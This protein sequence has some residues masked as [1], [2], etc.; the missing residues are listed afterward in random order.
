MI[1]VED[2]ESEDQDDEDEED[3]DDNL[4]ARKELDDWLAKQDEKVQKLIA[5]GTDGLRSALKKERDAAKKAAGL[6]KDLKDANKKLDA[7]K[8]DEEKDLEASEAA[9][10]KLVTDSAEA[11]KTAEDAVANLQK[12]RIKNAITI[13][14]L[15]EGFEDP[16]DAHALLAEDAV[17]IDE[18][19]DKVVGVKKALEKLLK[20]KPYLAGS[21][22]VGT[23]RGSRR[24]KLSSD[25]KAEPVDEVRF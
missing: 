22:E 17:T 3:D 1:Q 24:R 7:L 11:T 23:P 5:D 13:Q 2:K 14:A 4:D 25:D 19:T 21:D 18:K 20:D 15:K 12:E 16:E 8:T 9:H 10:A 6:E